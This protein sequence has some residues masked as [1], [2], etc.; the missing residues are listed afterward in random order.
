MKKKIR[1]FA[2]GGEAL[3]LSDKARGVLNLETGTRMTKETGDYWSQ[4]P[5]ALK[6]VNKLAN[7]DASGGGG[8]VLLKMLGQLMIRNPG[9]FKGSFTNNKTGES[10]PMK[11]GGKVTIKNK[12]RKVVKCT[13]GDGCAKRGKTKGR[14]V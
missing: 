7:I 5:D 13:R 4:R 14:M 11:K 10:I 3:N 6:F 2:E 12:T 9:S 1:K 8:P